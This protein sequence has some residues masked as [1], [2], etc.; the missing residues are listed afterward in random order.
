M[1]RSTLALV[2]VAALGLAGWS[3]W[4]QLDQP[5]RSVRVQGVLTESEREAIRSVVMEN[6]S[7]GVL[8]LDTEDLVRD[9]EALSWPRDVRV[10]RMWPD[11]L[12]IEVERESVVA[13]WGDGGYLTSAGK[14]V[15]I[16]GGPDDVPHLSAMMST[17]RQ[18]MEFYQRLTLRVAP[19]GLS[20]VRLDENELGEW[21]LTLAN[22]M[23]V[24]LGNEALSERL[25][26]FLLAYQRALSTRANAIAHV[27]TR[28]ANG[29]A[30]RWSEEQLASAGSTR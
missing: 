13:A 19:L 3:I 6:L 10:R 28:Y 23:T 14:V 17:P 11:A 22:G 12:A 4:L 2:V 20:I 9:I 21:M 15:R 5:V 18:T 1:L 30:V 8:S 24:A 25:S 27:D 29:I 16:A 7:A 26:R